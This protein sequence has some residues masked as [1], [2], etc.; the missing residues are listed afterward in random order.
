MRSGAEADF[1][2]SMPDWQPG[3]TIINFP[4]TD[5]AGRNQSTTSCCWWR[6][7]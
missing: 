1:V 7:N 3:W 4:C 2:T 5:S 6:R